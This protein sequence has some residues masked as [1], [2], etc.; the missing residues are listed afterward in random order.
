[1]NEYIE[2][3]NESIVESYI[4]SVYQEA[5]EASKKL[6]RTTDQFLKDNYTDADLKKMTPKQR[7]RVKKFLKDSDYDPKTNTIATDIV[8]RSGKPVRVKFTTKGFEDFPADNP[9]GTLAPELVKQTNLDIYKKMGLL[10]D[11]TKNRIKKSVDKQLADMGYDQPMVHMGKQWLKRKP[12]ISQG[13]RK[14][15]EGHVDKWLHTKADDYDHSHTGKTERTARK[16]LNS[17]K[18][19]L[20]DHDDNPEE[21]YADLYSV[22]HNKYQKSAMRLFNVLN[23]DDKM[24]RNLMKKQLKESGEFSELKSGSIYR[25]KQ[26]IRL[27][28]ESLE[29]WLK[30][31]PKAHPEEID[32]IKNQYNIYKSCLSDLEQLEK[33][34]EDKLLDQN[35]RKRY[36]DAPRIK[37]E[38]D[39]ESL[40]R[41]NEAQKRALQSELDNI[42]RKINNGAKLRKQFVQ[43]MVKEFYTIPDELMDVIQEMCDPWDII[44]SMV[45]ETSYDESS[46]D[47]FII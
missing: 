13:I 8:D 17:K 45:L 1:M 33:H 16:L 39:Q 30:D 27:N 10:N 15:E 37:A 23:S 22:K 9:G 20:N 6:R 25:F 34:F 32:F 3:N 2:F 24:I 36:R 12:Y 42:Y 5:N 18:Y 44:Q 41:F 4:D 19:N 26:K 47:S 14:H 7:N 28:V 35:G 11:V 40:V 31:N 43:N 38:R 46:I 21:N 29:Q